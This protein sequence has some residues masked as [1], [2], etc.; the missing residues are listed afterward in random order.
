M[1]LPSVTLDFPPLPSLQ[2]APDRWIGDDQPCFV[3]AEL[4]QNHNGDMQLARES[5]DNIAFHKSDA[6]KLCKRHII[7]EMTR[8]MYHMPYQG[9]QS[10]GE[11]YGKHREALE[12]SKEQY[13]E[14]KQYAEAKGLIFFSTACDMQS[15]D[16]LEEI[17]VGLYK[18]ASR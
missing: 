8:E 12:L 10:F 16:D 13:R 11:T 15:V 7:S 6:V 17:G 1:L 3:I 5:I 4:G 14:L 18:V 2:I 9:P